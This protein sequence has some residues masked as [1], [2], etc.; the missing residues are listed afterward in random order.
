M[1]GALHGESRD[2]V[3]T[4]IIVYFLMSVRGAKKM[5][6]RWPGSNQR[7]SGLQPDA[8][9]TELHRVVSC[10]H[11]C[12]FH[13]GRKK[14]GNSVAGIEPAA[15]WATTRCSPT[16]LHRVIG[17]GLRLRACCTV[18]PFQWL[19]DLLVGR[20]QSLL[21]TPR[22]LL[23]QLERDSCLRFRPFQFQ[24]QCQWRIERERR[25]RG[26][27]RRLDSRRG[28]CGRRTS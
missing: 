7:P 4:H 15:F 12:L 27:D 17:R 28:I 25:E 10:R 24:C 13:E 11:R 22:H 20:L 18:T 23:H 14:R 3:L 26:W 21:L 2:T 16:E 5:A 1:A 19:L 8:L 6:S 9:P